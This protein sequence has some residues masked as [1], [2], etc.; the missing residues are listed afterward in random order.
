M[1]LM[2]HFD[3]DRLITRLMLTFLLYLLL[4]GFIAFSLDVA[5][6]LLSLLSIILTSYFYYR[7][8]IYSQKRKQL[9][10]I[11]CFGLVTGILIYLKKPSIEEF[12]TVFF[13]NAI[14]EELIFR[15][16]MLG[17]LRSHLKIGVPL[18]RSTWAFVLLNASLFS[19]LHPHVYL[20]TFT[21]SLLYAYSF[22]R[23]G[24]VSA[25][26]FH[27]FWNFYHRFDIVLLVLGGVIAYESYYAWHKRSRT[28][29]RWYKQSK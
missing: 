3:I 27:V 23:L 7:D 29:F 13:R 19:L 21:L 26:A 17:I 1:V 25:I 11:I 6:T 15:F 24:I 28:I 18:R 2:K 10:N 14:G 12:L 4:V 22:L 8:G 20:S 5:L 9:V 16:G